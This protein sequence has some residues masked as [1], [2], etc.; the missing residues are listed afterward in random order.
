MIQNKGNLLV[1]FLSL[2]MAFRKTNRHEEPEAED[3]SVLESRR[4]LEQRIE[5]ALGDASESA[6]DHAA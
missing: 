5:L 3:P 1:S 6:K 2:L 4:K